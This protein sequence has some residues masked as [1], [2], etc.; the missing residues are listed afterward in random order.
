LIEAL[1]EEHRR[2]GS[3]MPDFLRPGID[4]QIVRDTLADL[5][6][7]ATDELVELFAWHDGTDADAYRASGRGLG[8]PRF[9]GIA[10]FAP[11][12]YATFLPWMAVRGDG[13]E[14]TSR[15][16]VTVGIPGVN[17]A[18]LGGILLLNG[19]AMARRS[20]TTTPHRL[21]SLAVAICLFGVALAAGREM[22]RW[23]GA[24]DDAAWV[25]ATWQAGLYAVALAGLLSA[26]AGLLPD[27]ARRQAA[28]SSPSSISSHYSVV[29]IYEGTGD[30]PVKAVT[31]TAVGN[32]GLS[33][34]ESILNTP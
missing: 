7:V 19:L 17:A 2:I 16:G 28:P 24:M 22:G 27:L 14:P 13:I 33:I 4:P 30:L 34:H 15:T 10:F 18:V 31:V 23:I 32:R 26:L 12:E 1:L 3:P 25:T 29:P 6:M 11:L 9:F 20:G 5:G 8:Y 21:A